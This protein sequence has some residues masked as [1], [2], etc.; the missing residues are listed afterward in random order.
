MPA[1]APAASVLI[2]NSLYPKPR[3]ALSSARATGGMRESQLASRTH[4]LLV[5]GVGSTVISMLEY[6][7]SY[8][9]YD[10]VV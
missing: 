2:G 4:S 10:L 9:G 3:A 8:M 1:V 6:F 5:Y 7:T